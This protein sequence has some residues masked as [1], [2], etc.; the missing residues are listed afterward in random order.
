LANVAAHGQFL[1]AVLMTTLSS[2]GLLLATRPLRRDRVLGDA[3]HGRDRVRMALGAT[4][5]HVVRLVVG[6]AAL[7]AAA[8]SASDSSALAT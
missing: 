5:R 8:R 4:A 6:Q 3:A 1:G 2:V 7:L